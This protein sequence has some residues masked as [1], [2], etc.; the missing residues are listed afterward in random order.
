MK[1]FVPDL[2]DSGI[3][4]LEKM[5]VYEPGKRIS[6]I[7]CLEHPFFDDL[8]ELQKLAAAKK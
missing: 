4:L 5:L 8:K 2:E 6:A 1:K 7:K 3:D